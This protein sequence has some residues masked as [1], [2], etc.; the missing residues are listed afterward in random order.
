MYE[1]LLIRLTIEPQAL[2]LFLAT[3]IQFVLCN[4]NKL[5][6]HEVIKLIRA[7]RNKA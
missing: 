5:Y 4:G 2:R 3:K 1:Y 6:I 7:N